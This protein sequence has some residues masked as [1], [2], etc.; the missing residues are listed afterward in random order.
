MLRELAG[1]FVNECCDRVTQD[2]HIVLDDYH[3][4]AE[5]PG[6]NVVID[7]LLTNLPE[8]V[9]LAVLSRYDPA[10][11]LSKVKLADQ[12]GHVG[13]DLLRL[14]AAQATA[15]VK[16]LTGRRFSLRHVDRLVHLTEGWPASIVLAALTMHRLDLVT[17][18]SALAGPR[19][20]QDVYSY[21]AE[22]VYRCEDDATRAFLKRTSCLE[23]IR[24]TIANRL[25]NICNAHVLLERLATNRVFT[26][27]AERRANTDTTISSATFCSRRTSR[28]RVKTRTIGS[29][30][31]RR[32]P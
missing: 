26:F 21:F 20:R 14:N 8:T 5:A 7:C 22:Q 23:S 15:V 4:A 1:V 2:L 29:S 18:E 31:T 10:F 24:P 11:S 9:H 30:A 13:V 19:L 6:L 12:V 3:E 32:K 28:M 16:S 27:P 25:G 17:L